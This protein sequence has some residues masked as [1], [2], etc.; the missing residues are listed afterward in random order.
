MMSQGVQLV[1]L[2]TGTP[3]LE[4]RGPTAAGGPLRGRLFLRL[5][6][7]APQ[8][9]THSPCGPRQAEGR[10]KSL[11]CALHGVVSTCPTPPNGCT[12]ATAALHPPLVAPCLTT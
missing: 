5:L 9:L 3:D 10:L 6:L 8:A 7:G 11:G 12:L 4:V 1:C 2:G